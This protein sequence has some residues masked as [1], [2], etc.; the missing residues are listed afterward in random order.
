MHQILKGLRKAALIDRIGAAL[1]IS[2]SAKAEWANRLLKNM[3]NIL[4]D[5]EQQARLKAW[6]NCLYRDADQFKERQFPGYR[7]ELSRQRALLGLP[8]E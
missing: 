7:Q 5:P 1:G 3:D 4:F 8:P 6:H 2:T